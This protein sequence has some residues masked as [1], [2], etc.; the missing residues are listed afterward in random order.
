MLIDSQSFKGPCI[1]VVVGVKEMLP[2]NQ[3]S[4]ADTW[5]I[6]ENLL[7]QNS[8]RLAAQFRLHHKT[9][10]SAFTI[11]FPDLTPYAFS[12]WV[13][14]LYHGRY[15]ANDATATPDTPTIDAD[16]E[17]WIIG[18]KLSCPAF[19]M[20][21]MNRIYDKYTAEHHPKPITTADFMHVFSSAPHD[22][23]LR[24]LYKN[25]LRVHYANTK[26][27]LGTTKEWDCVLQTHRDVRMLLLDSLR[28]GDAR[29]GLKINSKEFYMDPSHTGEK[30]ASAKEDSNSRALVPA[31]RTA[32]GSLVGAG[33]ATSGMANG[34][35]EKKHADT[36][37][38]GLQRPWQVPCGSFLEVKSI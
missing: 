30:Q 9:S 10:D 27:V 14:W 15:L 23:K 18:E 12:L 11:S 28:S 20:F 2:P 29:E 25:L 3:P 38:E 31:K 5:W 34:C 35:E 8:A 33:D 22:S 16:V 4:T 13:D 37:T 1:K 24:R 7:A 21:A 32:Q 26:R 17:A 6:H 19:K 36:G